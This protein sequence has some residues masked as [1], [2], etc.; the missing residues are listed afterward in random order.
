VTKLAWLQQFLRGRIIA[1][2]TRDEII[3]IGERKKAESSGSTANRYLALI[4]AILRKACHEW[5][6][7][8]KAPQVKLY[9]ESKRRV[10]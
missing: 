10:R 7:I 5:E 8:D 4:R 6:W 9:K 1:E 2:M 3:V